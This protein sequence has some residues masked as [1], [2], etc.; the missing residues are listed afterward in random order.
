MDDSELV[1]RMKKGDVRAGN[2]LYERYRSRIYGYCAHIL[3]DRERAVDATQETFMRMFKGLD[4]LKSDEA[5][6]PWL[7]AIARN[8]VFGLLKKSGEGIELQESD[9]IDCESPYDIVTGDQTRDVLE[10]LILSLSPIHREVIQLREYDDLSYE[11]I[12]QVIGIPLSSVKARLL[13]A[14]RALA[15][16][17]RRN[18]GKDDVC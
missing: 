16:R 5:F 9:A 6:R 18:Y 3:R 13:R 1:V 2:V 11:E 14:R 8:T 12:A 4:S 7:F 17:F 15:A 10:V